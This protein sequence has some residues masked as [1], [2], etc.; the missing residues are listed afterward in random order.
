MP[1]AGGGAEALA[2]DFTE[3]AKTESLRPVFF[4]PHSGQAGLRAVEERTSCSNSWPHSAHA[5]S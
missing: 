5:N 2:E 3:E 1:Q 4:A